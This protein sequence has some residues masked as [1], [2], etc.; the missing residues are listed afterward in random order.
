MRFSD[1]EILLAR[2]AQQFRLVARGAPQNRIDQR[3]TPRSSKR[4]CLENRRMF[5]G[6]EQ[7]KLVETEPQQ[8]ARL[9]I[10]TTRPQDIGPKIE[11]R[12]IA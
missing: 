12:E 6:L 5:R 9:V 11:K 4:D 3:S 1:T 2:F 7:K 10:E 8:I